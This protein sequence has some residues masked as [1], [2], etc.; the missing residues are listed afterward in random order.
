[1]NKTVFKKRKGFSLVEL[2]VVILIIAI[3]AVAVFAGGSAAIKKAQV[4]R[5]TSDLHNFSV[6][7]EAAIN[8]TPSVA[9][10]DTE[11]NFDPIISAVNSNLSADY[12]LERLT[13]DSTGNL[14]THQSVLSPANDA[15]KTGNYVIYKSAKT[16]AWDNP[17]YVIFDATER[18]NKGISEFY[19]TVVSA[20]PN[21]QTTIASTANTGTD[22]K[23]IEADD[24]FLLVQYTDGDVS[25]VTYNMDSDTIKSGGASSSDVQTE[26]GKTTKGVKASDKT[27]GQYI[28]TVV[29]G[30]GRGVPCPVNF[31]PSA[32]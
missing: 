5:T 7:I 9:N 22:G 27:Q 8:E 2:V 26:L 28:G 19:I 29:N 18:H 4:S 15:A 31:Q 20:G 30:D 24:I 14:V 17:Y 32:N 16:D 12:Q 3:L 21:A 1:M 6:A 25:S 10:M 11:A 13:V 23:G